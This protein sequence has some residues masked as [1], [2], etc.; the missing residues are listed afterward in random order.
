MELQKL[1]SMIMG[2]DRHDAEKILIEQGDFSI[3]EA[4]EVTTIHTGSQ[5]QM[6]VGKSTD[7]AD[8]LNACVLLR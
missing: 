2:M 3:I 8:S 1:A 6:I 7:V 4:A 5:S